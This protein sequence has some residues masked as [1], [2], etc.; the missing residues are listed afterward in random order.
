VFKRLR[1]WQAAAALTG[2][3]FVA[4]VL[5]LL[6]PHD[7]AGGGSEELTSLSPP[8]SEIAWNAAT[9]FFWFA[10]LWLVFSVVAWVRV[11]RARAG[12]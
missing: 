4:Q 1:P 11:R 2:V 10:V 7:S 6:I 9:V 3:L 8:P 12:V 5:L